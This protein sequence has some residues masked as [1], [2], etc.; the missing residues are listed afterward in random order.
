M[1]HGKR[2]YSG[3]TGSHAC[4]NQPLPRRMGFLVLACANEQLTCGASKDA[5]RTRSP[6]VGPKE[7]SISKV[8]HCAGHQV[9]HRHLGLFPRNCEGD[10]PVKALACFSGGTLCLSL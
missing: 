2:P 4:L 5:G 10:T 3:L 8:E 9:G 1:L 6:Q 7:E